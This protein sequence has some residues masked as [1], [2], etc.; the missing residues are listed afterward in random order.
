MNLEVERLFHELADLA[1][2][3]RTRYFDEHRV[4]PA[5]RDEVE[6]LLTSDAE[7]SAFLVRD[8]RLAATRLLPQVDPQGWRCGPYRL[9]RLLGRG[10][11]GAVYL[12]ERADGEVAQRAAVKLLPPG[13][14]D[15][16]IERFLQERQILASLAHPNIARMLDAGH[17]DNGQPFLA[18]EYVDGTPIDGFTAGFGVRRKIALFL[19][20]C[21]AVAYLH[22]NLIVHRDLK[23]GNILVT[24]EGEPKL[25]DFGIAKML[26][27]STDSTVTN[28]RML[29]PDYASPEQVTGGRVSTATDI[30]SLGA[31]LY[32]LLTGRSA[33]EFADRTPEA[34]TNVV[35]SRAI[36]RPSKWAPELKGDLE[37]ILMKAL[38]KDPQERYGTVEQFAEDLQAF[39]ESRTVRARSGN[40]WYRMR[41][42][43]RR[44]WLPLAA[45]ALVIA[46]LSVG[47][48]VANR[49]RAVA[50]RRFDQVR[51]LANK[52]LALDGVVRALPGSTKARSEIVAMSQQY[53]EGLGA[54]TGSDPNLVIDVANSYF[55]LARVQGIPNASNLGQYAQ[56]EAS[57]RKA[58]ALLEPV[59]KRSPDNRQALLLGANVAHSLMILASTDH[60]RDEMLRDAKT[61]AERMETL[62]SLG[63]ASPEETRAAL[64]IFNNIALAH[65]NQHLY[66]DAIRYAKRAIEIGR[67]APR[68]T[69]NLGNPLS[70]LADSLRFSGDLPGALQAIQEARAD[71]EKASFPGE[72]MRASAVFNVLWREGTIL[73][74]DDCISLERPGEAAAVLQQAFDMVNNWARQDPDNAAS[75]ILLGSDA[76]ELGLI[77]AHTDPR[78]ALAIDDEAIARLREVR[79][80]RDARRDE[81]RLLAYSSRVLQL[82]HRSGE[83]AARIDAAFHLLAGTRDYPAASVSPGSDAFAVVD[84]LGYHLAENGEP[85]KSA[86]V[87]SDLLAKVT[88][89]RPDPENDLRDASKLSG[90]YEAMAGVDGRIGQSAE[91]ANFAG[92]RVE[93]WQHWRSKLPDNSF[94]LHQLAAAQASGAGK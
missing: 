9:L 61:A 41:K 1:P 36:T 7:A 62:L 30:Y 77:V 21:S 58:E 84:A 6:A 46:S 94:V 92:R 59:L 56:A 33:H 76:R 45:A 83:A 51:R 16:Q 28:M 70:V 79:N 14:C 17:V 66:A 29:T 40:G 87:Y 80:N 82:L 90:L 4:E 24:A 74:Q 10:G 22:R 47:L 60:R 8:I 15:P 53:L 44:Y 39:L 55:V 54:E 52:V 27:V 35:L 63:A 91:A 49:A 75:R 48:Y 37:F 81:A 11:M 57:L 3:A 93:I 78:R 5:T 64:Q 42:F 20:V 34:I 31:V 19:K 88:A 32:H 50:Q 13:A 12:A 25:L 72:T 71:V 2:D 69:V 18:M 68:G 89:A 38:R 67:L 73:G 86:A 65:K 23:P 43:L 26:D 85:E